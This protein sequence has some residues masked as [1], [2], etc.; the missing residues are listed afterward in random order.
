M[1]ARP[2][3]LTGAVTI[4]VGVACVVVGEGGKPDTDRLVNAADQALTEAKRL[5]RNQ[6]FEAEDE[7]VTRAGPRPL[8]KLPLD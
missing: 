7:Y 8:P 2:N 6:V 4:S 3:E 1:A 5:G